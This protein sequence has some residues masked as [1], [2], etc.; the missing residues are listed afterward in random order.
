VHVRS[1][2]TNAQVLLD[3]LAWSKPVGKRAVFEF[4]V[5]KGTKYPFEM[6]NVRLDGDNV[7][8]AGWMAAD[9]DFVVREYRFPQ[10]SLNVV[11]NLEAYGTLRA[12]NVW[13]IR[14]KGKTFDG[15]DLFRSFF[16]PMPE[17]VDPTKPGVDV[18]A[19]VDTVLGFVGTSL[20]GVQIS[21]QRRNG[22]LTRLETHGTMVEARGRR[23]RGKRLEAVLRPEPGRPRLLLIRAND[24]GLAFKLVGFLPH[25]IG[26]DMNLDVD[27]DGG[28]VADRTGILLARNFHLLGEPLPPD[29]FQGPE[30]GVQK[31]GLR[32]RIPFDILRL[33]FSVGH[34]RFDLREASLRGPVF[35][36]TGTGSIDFRTKRLY[37]HGTFTPFAG[38]N[39]LFRDIPLFGDIMTGPKGEGMFA[40]NFALQGG[41]DSPQVTVN[42]LS[43]VAPGFT[44]DLF[45]IMP[46]EPR[47]VSRR[48]ASRRPDDGARAS[49]SLARGP[50]AEAPA[51][52]DVGDGWLSEK[53]WSTNRRR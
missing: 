45:P 43:G 19:E 6:P 46:E 42:P 51:S 27:L 14:A 3:S 9:A 33:P 16:N 20:R 1:D 18:H 53:A 44:R 17:K 41:L 32:E 11:S 30:R 49:S 12:D 2:L 22:K 25:A 35:S 37:V 47:S 15:R 36:A 23:A 7:A 50:R 13:E 29:P 48:G 24:A 40:L 5:V 34:G 21:L 38:I 52:A 10:F 8:I 26:G 39:Q 4:D 31:R 28:G